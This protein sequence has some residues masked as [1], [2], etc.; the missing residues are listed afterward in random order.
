[1][2]NYEQNFSHEL[3][4]EKPHEE[5]KS[6]KLFTA[7]GSHIL[8]HTYSVLGITYKVLLLFLKG[9]ISTQILNEFSV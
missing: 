4:T 2:E 6:N 1:M 8:H 9:N 5:T 7:N 3:E